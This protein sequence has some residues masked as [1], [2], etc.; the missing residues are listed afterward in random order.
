MDRYRGLVAM[1][2]EAGRC[3]VFLHNHILTIIAL[4]DQ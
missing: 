4:V 3:F 1:C 2:P